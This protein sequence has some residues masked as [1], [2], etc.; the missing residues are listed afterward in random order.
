VIEV[1]DLIRG[2]AG[3]DGCFPDFRFGL[4]NQRIIAA[5][6]RSAA[7]GARAEIGG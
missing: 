2:I 5:M 1:H 6:E 4:E 3:D 7:S